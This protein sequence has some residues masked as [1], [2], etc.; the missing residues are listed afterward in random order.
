MIFRYLY[1]SDQWPSTNIGLNSFT[2]LIINEFLILSRNSFIK[3]SIDK[4]KQIS[5]HSIIHVNI[6]FIKK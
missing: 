4:A 6:N 1:Q 2:E 5:S 3:I